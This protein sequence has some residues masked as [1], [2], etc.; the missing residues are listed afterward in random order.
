MTKAHW[1]AFCTADNLWWFVIPLVLLI[2]PLA[3]LMIL[4]LVIL[5]QS[6]VFLRWGWTRLTHRHV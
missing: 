5:E 2:L 1:K 3:G 6:T 4:L